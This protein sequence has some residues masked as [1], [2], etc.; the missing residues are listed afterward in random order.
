MKPTPTPTPR[1]R[2]RKWRRI[3]A[4]QLAHRPLCKHCWD[5]GGFVVE[6]TEHE[7]LRIAHAAENA[8]VVIRRI[9]LRGGFHPD[10]LVGS[11]RVRLARAPVCLRCRCVVVRVLVS[12]AYFYCAATTCASPGAAD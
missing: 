11:A 6:A 3:M 10:L 1:T 9:R 4:R 5:E 12:D 2:E 7:F 8:G